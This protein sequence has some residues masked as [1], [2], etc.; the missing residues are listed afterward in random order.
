MKGSL[1]RLSQAVNG[2]LSCQKTIEW[3]DGQKQETKTH[4]AVLKILKTG[5]WGASVGLLLPL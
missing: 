5:M 4:V 3:H 1:E 2:Y